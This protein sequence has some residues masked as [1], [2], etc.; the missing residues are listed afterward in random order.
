M[1]LKENLPPKMCSY[2]N[3]LPRNYLSYIF[4]F[5]LVTFAFSLILGDPFMVSPP[6]LK[7]GERDFFLKNAFH[8]RTN[9]VGKAYKGIVLHGGTNDLIMPRGKEFHKIHYPVL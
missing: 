8:G 2:D 6:P 4:E 7:Y 5:Q 3:M 1:L 9:F